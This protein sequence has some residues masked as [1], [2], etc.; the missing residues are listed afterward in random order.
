MAEELMA[1]TW[2][3]LKNEEEGDLSPSPFSSDDKYVAH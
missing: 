1:G 2:C 3:L